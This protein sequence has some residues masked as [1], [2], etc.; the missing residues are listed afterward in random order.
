MS[1]ESNK[2]M[3]HLK[4]CL[5]ASAA[6]VLNVMNGHAVGQHLGLSQ[7]STFSIDSTVTAMSWNPDG[8]M[9][10]VSNG[11][12]VFTCNLYGECTSLNEED[13]PIVRAISWHPS[14]N[15]LAT[16]GN[17]FNVWNISTGENLEIL[18]WP[19]KEA[20]DGV[21][22]WSNDGKWLAFMTTMLVR[23]AQ[24]SSVFLWNRDK[25]DLTEI[26]YESTSRVSSLAFSPD[27]SQLVIATPNQLALWDF[28]TQELVIQPGEY[29]NILDIAYHPSDKTLAH[30]AFVIEERENSEFLEARHTIFIHTQIGSSEAA[31]SRFP[32]SLDMAITSLAWNPLNDDVLVTGEVD[33]T[34]RLWDVSQGE[35]ISVLVDNEQDFS[36]AITSVSWSPLGNHLAIAQRDGVITIFEQEN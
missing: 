15:L 26:P 9:L 4:L 22:K 6:F 2:T 34:V 5:I 11:D 31:R 20:V 23:D 29:E 24:L 12:D 3:R 25:G 30:S 13:I 7:M 16:S 8:N 27:D 33:G 1:F 32:S 21:V 36:K 17:M 14:D 28:D 35:A 10:A 19:E 18:N